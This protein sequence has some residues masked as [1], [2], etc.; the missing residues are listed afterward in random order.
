MMFCSSLYIISGGICYTFVPLVVRS[1]PIISARLLKNK[2][3]ILLSELIVIFVGK[4]DT[5]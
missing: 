4:R 1:M 3:I 2:V 5:L